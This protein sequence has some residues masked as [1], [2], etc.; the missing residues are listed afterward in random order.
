MEWTTDSCGVRL[1]SL[2][3]YILFILLATPD[4]DT[5]LRQSETV[6]LSERRGD[7]N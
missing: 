7:G 1:R 3:L 5:E 4:R 6:E 2:F